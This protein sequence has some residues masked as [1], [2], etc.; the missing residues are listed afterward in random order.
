MN[1]IVEHVVAFNRA[2]TTGD[3][4]TFALRFA[5]DASMSFVDVPAGPYLGRAAIA[6]AY[7][8]N[9]PTETMNLIEASEREAAD[10]ARFRWASGRTGTMVL[11]WAPDGSVQALRVSF[12]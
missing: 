10:V 2:V 5:E 8:D 9:P 6:G 4:D 3:W 11:T 12:D 1:R 7:R